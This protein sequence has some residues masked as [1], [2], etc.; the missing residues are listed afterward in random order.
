ME[1]KDNFY[2]TLEEDIIL[3]DDKKVRKQLESKLEEY[4]IRASEDRLAAEKEGG[5]I[6][7][8]APEVISGV[9]RDSYF[10]TKVLEKL[11]KDGR[12][13]I[14]YFKQDVVSDDDIMY[15]KNAFGVIKSYVE[16][17]GEHVV[18]GTGLPEVSEE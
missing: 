13:S 15:L 4:K 3:P 12:V 11:V 8:T 9:S 2:E 10:K 18:G 5:N 1:Q 7:Y 16:A 14:S 17:G 6:V